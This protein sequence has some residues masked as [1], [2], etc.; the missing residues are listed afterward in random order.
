MYKRQLL[1]TVGMTGRQI[2]R[3]MYRQMLWIASIGMT[4]GLAVGSLAVSYTHL[5]GSPGSYVRKNYQPSKLHL[6]LY[7]YDFILHDRKWSDVFQTA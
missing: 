5:G 7:I 3:F 4:A 1:Q 2:H 6:Q